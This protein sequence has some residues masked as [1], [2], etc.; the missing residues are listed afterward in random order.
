M[1]TDLVRRPWGNGVDFYRHR[2]D[3]VWSSP[4]NERSFTARN[5]L[6]ANHR[7]GLTNTDKTIPIFHRSASIYDRRK[8]ITTMGLAATSTTPPSLAPPE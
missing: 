5:L 7:Y 2:Q 8:F 1:L 4:L 6:L 3:G